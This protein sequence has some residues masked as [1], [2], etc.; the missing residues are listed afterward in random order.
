MVVEW[1]AFTGTCFISNMKK[2]ISMIVYVLYNIMILKNSCI[3]IIITII[4]NYLR[5]QQAVMRNYIS[6]NIKPYSENVDSFYLIGQRTYSSLS[7]LS[8]ANLVSLETCVWV[9]T[10]LW[11]FSPADTKTC[12][13]FYPNILDYFISNIYFIPFS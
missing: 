10:K 3:I 7:P 1:V 5:L 9:F 2:K 8:F 12:N 6:Y 13:D 11:S 4:V